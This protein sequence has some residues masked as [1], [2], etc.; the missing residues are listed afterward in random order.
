MSYRRH[1]VT[2]VGIEIECRDANQN[3]DIGKFVNRRKDRTP[4]S[5]NQR[6]EILKELWIPPKEYKF[7]ATG[8]RKLKFQIRWLES[9][10]WL[11]YSDCQ[12][13]AFCKMCVLFASSGIGNS[14]DQLPGK[15]VTESFSNWKNALEVFAKHA[16][17]DYHIAATIDA[18]NLT[19]TLTRQASVIL[20]LDNARMKEIRENREKLIPII[21][22][23]LFCGRQGIALRGHRDHGL[24]GLRGV[25]V[26]VDDS[27]S[28]MENVNDGNFRALLR[29]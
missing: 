16:K 10:S 20:Q 12:K 8:S 9:F 24:Q 11:A 26:N 13:G 1:G 7:E 14:K 17:Y 19:K 21:N 28:E 25:N 2:W 4:L 27:K 5:S 3:F 22:T 6:L 18:D 15:L 29:F 23:V